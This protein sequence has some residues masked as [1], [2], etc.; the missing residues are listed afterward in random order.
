MSNRGAAVQQL[1]STVFGVG[2]QYGVMLPFSRKHEYEAD[3][4]GM[5]LM[6]IAGY[7]P[8]A[9]L[10]FWQKM[11]AGTQASVPEYM[12]THPSDANRIAAI[13]KNLAGI[14]AKYQK[15]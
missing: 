7:D 5:A 8:N 1:A 3:Y 2:A 10:A 12:S 4:I 11:S 13:K 6:T 14:K 9:A 15:K